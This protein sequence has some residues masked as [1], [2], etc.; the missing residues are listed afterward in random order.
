MN[1]PI[2]EIFDKAELTKLTLALFKK[3]AIM[4]K[5][6]DPEIEFSKYFINTMKKYY[7]FITFEQMED[8]FERNAIGSLDN[9]LPKSGYSVNNK[10]S[11]CISD[12][13]KIMRAYLNYKAPKHAEKE[14]VRKPQHEI[15][16]IH[17]QWIAQLNQIFDKYMNEL[18]RTHISIPIYYCDFLANCNLLD[19]DKIDRKE[20]KI[21]IKFGKQKFKPSYNENLVYKCFTEILED[22]LVLNDLIK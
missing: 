2:K 19:R 16:E 6:R 22:G 11:F 10:V 21:K 12:M 14:E 7:G 17:R 9:F 15:D 8:A 3:I 18:E 1:R 13:T 20:S 5:L 4:Y